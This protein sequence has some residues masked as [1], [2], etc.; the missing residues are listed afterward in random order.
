MKKLLKIFF[1]FLLINLPRLVG[2][3]IADEYDL[4]AAFLER[5]TRFIEWSPESQ[6]DDKDKYF[7]IV[8][9]GDNP[10]GKKLDI[11]YAKQKIKDKIVK[12]RY[13][14]SIDEIGNCQMLFICPS[15]AY[16]LQQVLNKVSKKNILTVSQTDGFC[17]KGVHINFFI[18]GSRLKFQ[19]NEKAVKNSNLKIS[20]LLLQNATIINSLGGK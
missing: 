2:A 17:E 1:I 7:E 10:F 20:R 6:S 16:N 13:T 3:E 12:I 4:K 9:I 8:V 19:I 5:F 11:L 14:K 15:M 18:S